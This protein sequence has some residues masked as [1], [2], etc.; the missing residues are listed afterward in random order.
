[1]IHSGAVLLAYLMPEPR[2]HLKRPDKPSVN[3]SGALD[4]SSCHVQCEGRLRCF[5]VVAHHKAPRDGK[6]RRTHI[7]AVL[8]YLASWDW[9]GIQPGAIWW[10]SFCSKSTSSAGYRPDLDERGDSRQGSKKGGKD[11]MGAKGVQ[12]HQAGRSATKPSGVG[13]SGLTSAGGS[14][15]VTGDEGV[16]ATLAVCPGM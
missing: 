5:D 13:A 15:R 4:G 2:H 9:R 7:L 1:M 10:V 6:G 16:P 3:H 14:F 11:G 12:S 8:P